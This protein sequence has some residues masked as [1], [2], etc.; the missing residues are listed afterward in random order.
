MGLRCLGAAAHQE[1]SLTQTMFLR[2]NTTIPTQIQALRAATGIRRVV[3]AGNELD[4]VG[5]EDRA[6]SP[7]ERGETSKF[8]DASSELS[9]MAV[10]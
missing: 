9:C 7:F 1:I 3:V 2:Y 6:N 8:R 10:R 4:I 5:R